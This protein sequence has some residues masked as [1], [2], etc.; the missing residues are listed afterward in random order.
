MLDTPQAQA[1]NLEKKLFSLMLNFLVLKLSLI[2]DRDAPRWGESTTR[3][4]N[5]YHVTPHGL[6]E[7]H[8]GM[9]QVQE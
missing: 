1:Q 7:D 6:I 4:V 8:K 3:L 2:Y 9:L 5:R